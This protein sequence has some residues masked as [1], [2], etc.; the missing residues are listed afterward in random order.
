MP[1]NQGYESFVSSDK[2]PVSSITKK[3]QRHPSIKLIKTE[4]KSKNFGFG[5]TNIDEIKKFIEKLDPKKAFQKSDMRTN[6]LIKCSFFR[7]VHLR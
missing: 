1:K 2:S 5:E 4:N 3:Y 6:I 7:Q